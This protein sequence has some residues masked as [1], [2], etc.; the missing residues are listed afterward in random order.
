MKSFVMLFFVVG[1]VMLA[2]GYQNKV[3]TN[4]RT[5]TIVEYRY[6]PRTLY[7]EQMGPTN[8]E[9]NFTTM[10]QKQDVFFRQS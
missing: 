9:Q 1:I 5:K 6:I 4:T 3:I 8:L 2:I 10:F 7:D